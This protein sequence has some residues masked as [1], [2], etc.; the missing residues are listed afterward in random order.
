[1][2]SKKPHINMSL[3]IALALVVVTFTAI[4]AGCSRSKPQEAQATLPPGS[5]LLTG[6]GATFPSVLYNRWFTV[7]RDSHP[8]TFIK[9]AA[10][11]SGEGVRRFIGTPVDEEEKVDFG[12]SDATMSDAEIARADQGTLMV[13]LTAGCVVLA[14]NLPDVQDLK[15]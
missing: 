5:I 14:Y 7:Y 8:N 11:G 1:M 4:L 13:P 10:V 2:V 3:R 6:A 12:A 9:Y 15:L